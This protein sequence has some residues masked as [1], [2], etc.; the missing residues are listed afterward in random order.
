MIYQCGDIFFVVTAR[1]NGITGF[2]SR[3]I[4]K[5]MGSRWSHTAV[6]I[7]PAHTVETNATRVHV[8]AIVDHTENLNKDYEVYRPTYLPP[9]EANIIMQSS[10]DLVNAGTKYSYMQMLAL[11]LRLLFNRKIPCLWPWGYV[12]EG[13]VLEGYSKTSIPELSGM[14]H[15]SVD[16][17]ELYQI[18]INSSRFQRIK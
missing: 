10:L 3:L 17:E 9:E 4:A 13:V 18:I 11:G 5:C 12:C 1:N 16:T 8:N 7:D 14:K 6:V 15:Y 2:M